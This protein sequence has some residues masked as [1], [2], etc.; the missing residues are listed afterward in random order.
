MKKENKNFLYNVIYQIFSLLMPLITAPYIARVL[1]VDNIG[2][3]SYTYSIVSYFMLAALLGVN[4]YGSREIAK[5]A[6]SGDKEKLSRLFCEVYYMQLILGASMLVLY[7]IAL[8]FFGG[9]YKTIFVLQGIFIVSAIF[10]INWFYFGLENFKLTVSRNI[11]IKT[12]SLILIFIFVKN[13][14]DLA[15]YVLILSLS[16]LVSQLYLWLYIRK[17][18]SFVKRSLNDVFSHFKQCLILFV[19]VV[20]YSIYRIMDKT[21]LGAISGTIPLGYYQNAE[22]IINIPVALVAALGT[23]MLPSMSKKMETREFNKKLFGSFELI[24]LFVLPVVV[25]L[26]NVGPDLA[27]VFYGGDF[28]ESGYIIRVLAITILF[29]GVA[30]VV[31]TNYLIPRRKDKVY[32]TSTILGAVINLI[33]NFI[34]IPQFGVYGACIGTIA[35]ELS[36]M[37]YQMLRTRDFIKYSKVLVLFLKYLLKSVPIFVAQ[38]I[39]GFMINGTLLRLFCNVVITIVLFAVI[40]HKYI[41]YDFFGKKNN[42]IRHG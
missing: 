28:A 18:A 20:A 16:T 10:D 8:P 7:F 32:V 35:A 42:R 25:S 31:R 4:N 22:S 36:V 1:G 9:Q 37:L 30:N 40:N 33:L 24:F 17:Y 41:L 12:L 27:V 13:E 3:Y 39:I 21:M 2:I 23:V 26:I 19:P 14:A 6:Q 34:F 5:V 11:I 38:L 29:A 15:K